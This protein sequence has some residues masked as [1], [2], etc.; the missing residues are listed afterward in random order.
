M[1]RKNINLIA[2]ICMILLLGGISIKAQKPLDLEVSDI[3]LTK[4]ANKRFRS[5]IPSKE[6]IDFYSKNPFLLDEVSALFHNK[7]TK[8]IKSVKWEYVIYKDSAE[9]E[10]AHTYKNHSKILLQP[11]ESVRLQKSGYNLI[12]SPYKQIKITQ[13]VYTDGSIWR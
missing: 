1:K 6:Y 13:I 10:I 2:I 11:D 5:L 8:T 12:Q 3:K 4:D 9:T 7:G